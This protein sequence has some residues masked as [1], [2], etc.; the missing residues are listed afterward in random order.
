MRRRLRE[1]SKKRKREKKVK[2][3]KKEQKIFITP[4]ASLIVDLITLFFLARV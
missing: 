3:K 4:L 1:K 2:K